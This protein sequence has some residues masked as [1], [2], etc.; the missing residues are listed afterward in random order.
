MTTKK[1]LEYYSIYAIIFLILSNKK[2]MKEYTFQED[3]QKRFQKDPELK[4]LFQK[5]FLK[6]ML[7]YQI[8]KIRKK[9]KMTQLDLAKKAG[10][11]QS[12]IARIES[13]SQ[14]ISMKTLQK[15]IFALDAQIEIKA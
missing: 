11:T 5:Q 12:V 14:N 15:L 9:R 2:G 1:D 10:T 3:L 8:T 13:G 4:D 7:S 6:D